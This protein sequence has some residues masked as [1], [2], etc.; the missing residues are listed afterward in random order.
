MKEIKI[1]FFL[2]IFF[3]PQFSLSAEK[4][5]KG[6]TFEGTGGRDDFSYLK[7]KNSDFK[8]GK[9]AFKQAQKFKKKNKTEKANKRFNDAIEYFLLAYNDFPESKEILSYLGVIY[10]EIG[11]LI[12]AEIYFNEGLI[13]DPKNPEIN[14][15]LGEL[16]VNTKRINLAKERLKALRTCNCEEYSI[17][18]NILKKDY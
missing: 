2:I 9:D 17:L 13:I 3:F 10:N 4:K 15:R 5:S 12:M 6:D 8:K 18:K 7:A 14:Q 1:F 16:Y 11:D